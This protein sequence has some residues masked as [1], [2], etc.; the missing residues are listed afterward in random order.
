MYVCMCIYIYVY[1][2]IYL[3]THTH[4]KS[5]AMES[6]RDLVLRNYT[7]THSVTKICTLKTHTYIIYI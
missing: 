6:A 2:Y 4:H 7:R 3:H 1:I 5:L